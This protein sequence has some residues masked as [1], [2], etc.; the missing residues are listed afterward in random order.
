M[1]RFSPYQLS[2]SSGP[3]SVRIIVHI[4]FLALLFSGCSFYSPRY[5]PNAIE[6]PGRIVSKNRSDLK[7]NFVRYQVRYLEGG[8]IDIQS[9]YPAFG[10]G[11]CV[12]VFLHESSLPTIAYGSRCQNQKISFSPAN[13]ILDR[14]SPEYGVITEAIIGQGEGLAKGATAGAAVGVIGPLSNPYLL[15]HPV[16]IP[17]AVIVGT[18]VGSI[19]GVATAIPKEL[20]SKIEESLND[21]SKSSDIHELLKHSLLDEASK[22]EGLQLRAAD[23]LD[24]ETSPTDGDH[25]QSTPRLAEMATLEIK[26]IKVG[27]KVYKASDPYISFSTSLRTTLTPGDKEI[28][29][30]ILYFLYQSKT[31]K[32]LEDWVEDGFRQL[33]NESHVASMDLAGRIIEENF[34]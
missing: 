23:E 20:N 19:A 8:T 31:R 28:S 13:L 21:F 4:L 12:N 11:D 15:L 9:T 3:I 1:R 27:F 33:K 16:I 2:S 5:D 14:T 18:V 6:K 26:I 24:R 10:L 29:P 34:D 7:D 17:S 22:Y 25:S 30:T 32:T